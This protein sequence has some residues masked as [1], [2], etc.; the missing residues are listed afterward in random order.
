MTPPSSGQ[1][2]ITRFG[3]APLGSVPTKILPFLFQYSAYH[4][5][6]NLNRIVFNIFHT[7]HLRSAEFSIKIYAEL[8]L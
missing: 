4:T 8:I 3:L 2:L 1:Q 7:F 6:T 5:D